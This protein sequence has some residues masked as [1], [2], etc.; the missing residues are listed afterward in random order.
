MLFDLDGVL[1]DSAECVER[2]W[3]R[4]AEANDLNPAEVI[5]AAHG[6]RTIETIQA[7]APHLVAGAEV[8]RLAASE[9]KETEGVYEIPGARELLNSLTDSSW[10]VVTSG[11]RAVAELRMCHTGLRAPPVLIWADEIKVGKPNP[12]GYLIAAARLGVEPERC[13]V[14]EDA[15][16]G[17]EA[18]AR[19]S[20]MR[21]I[22]ITGTYEG[23]ALASADRIVP[24]VAWMEVETSG[25]DLQV[26]LREPRA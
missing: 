7:V 1:V 13:V 25:S 21:A 14:I 17:I 3:H 8:A 12:E 11:I 16:P 26:I 22:G 2:T 19:A 18:A 15:P 5:R 4:W 23:D 10:A 9:S 6:R 24:S 20:G